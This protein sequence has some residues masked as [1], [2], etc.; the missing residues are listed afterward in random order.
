MLIVED[1]E[2]IRE[3]LRRSLAHEAI[4]VRE[5]ADGIEGMESIQAHGTPDLI[6]LDLMMPRLDGFG[7]LRQLRAL[8]DGAHVPVVVLTA[9]T[10]S[11]RERDVL[12]SNV[13]RVFSKNSLD[14]DSLRSE[15]MAL[16][17]RRTRAL[18]DPSQR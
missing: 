2:P 3:I 5:A 14:H 4:E 17:T 8:P 12:L 9:K 13:T 15:V 18:G 1:S 7:F 16:L 6:L 10:L 11:M